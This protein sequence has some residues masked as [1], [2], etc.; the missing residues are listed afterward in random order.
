MLH[1][2]LGCRDHR[3][4]GFDG[5]QPSDTPAPRGRRRAL[6]SGMVA[7]AFVCTALVSAAQAGMVGFEVL[8]VES[9]ALEGRTFGDVGAVEKIVGRATIALD[10]ADPRNAV[11]ADIDLAPKNA[12]GL[13]EAVADVEIL[14]PLEGGNGTILLEVPNRGRKLMSILFDE[15]GDATSASRLEQASDAGNG[16]LLSQ[17]YTLVWVGWQG[18]LPAKPGALRIEVPVLPA[19]TGLSREEFVFDHLDDPVTMPLTY[20]AAAVPGDAELTVR[21]GP[22]DKREQPADLSFR[23][24]DPQQVEISRPEGFDAG[25]IYELIYTAKEPLVLGMGFAAVRDVVAFL[26][27]ETEGNPLGEPAIHAYAHGVSQSGRFLRDY[28]YLGFNEDE[29]GR[30]V[31]DAMNPHI[32]GTRRTY[33]N[34]RFAQAGRNPSSQTDRLYQAD[35]FPF[36]YAVTLDPI[37]G[38]RDGLMA[39]CRLSNTCPKVIETDS[40]VELFGSRGSLLVTDTEGN[41]IDLPSDVRA[42]MIAGHPHFASPAS[43]ASMTDACA[44]WRNPLHAGAPMRALLVALDEWVRQGIEPPASRYPMLAH[45]TLAPADG[46]YPEIPGLAYAGV[47]TPAQLVD[48]AKMPPQPVASYPVLFPRVDADGLAMGGIR[49]PVIEAPLATYTGWNPRAVGYGAGALCTNQG[50]VIPFA[51]TRA[52]RLEAGD[53]RPSIEERYASESA[54][55]GE[56]RQASE[57]LV[58]ERLLLPADAEAMIEAAK[59][60]ELAGLAPTQ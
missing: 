10:P 1:A 24:L 7:G 23:F 56:V 57:R 19:V 22:E 15:T 20:A 6:L 25:A 3:G 28:L 32:P 34:F 40:E 13:V 54:Y 31:F 35:Q 14:R 37:S 8:S 29:Q 30:I 43:V 58:A 38:R 26:R 42:Y 44:L 21:A 16:F 46:L 53:P 2:A 49:L 18:D 9:P 39:R 47:H 5:D 17:G 52:G 59:A 41:H 11:I 36:T 33:T 27:N 60:G 55:V 50:A 45:G 4:P 48:Y 51:K 12:H